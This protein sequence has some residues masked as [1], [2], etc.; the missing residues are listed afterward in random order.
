MTWDAS[1]VSAAIPSG[2]GFLGAGLIFKKE[3]HNSDGSDSTPMVHGLTTA[4]SLWLS[5]AVGIA[6]GGELY[7]AA[8]FGTA[9]MILLLRF[10]PRGDDS[11]HDDS[12]DEQETLELF[13]NAD[14]SKSLVRNLSMQAKEKKL[15]QRANLAS[16]V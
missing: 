6:C 4:A 2:V 1:R 15:R 7:F 16:I 5:A 13:Q 8:S 14:E 12:D 11:K 9:T 10:G 3:Q